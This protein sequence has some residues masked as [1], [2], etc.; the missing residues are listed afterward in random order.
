MSTVVSSFIQYIMLYS[1]DVIEVNMQ[2]GIC[3][4]IIIRS[5]YTVMMSVRYTENRIY[6][7]QSIHVHE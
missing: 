4:I 5:A 2:M 3:K 1:G 7:M 6:V